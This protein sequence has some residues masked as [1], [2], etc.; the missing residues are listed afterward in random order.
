[1]GLFDKAFETTSISLNNNVHIVSGSVDPT[2]SGT[3]DPIGSLYLR[4]DGN[5]YRKTGAGANAWT[6][7]D[8]LESHTHTSSDVTD[9]NEAA[10]DAIATAFSN[11]TQTG[12]TINYDDVNNSFSFNVT[13]GGGGSTVI[14]DLTS[15]T[16]PQHALYAADGNGNVVIA[17]VIDGG[18]F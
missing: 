1:M 3:D 4:T 9:F 7:T 2:V 14:T 12:L 5:V 18:T 16:D 10:Q 6:L 11:G 13:G 15:G 8:Q 17:T